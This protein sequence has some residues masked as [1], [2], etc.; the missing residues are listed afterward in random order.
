MVTFCYEATGSKNSES[1]NVD[2][3]GVYVYLDVY[4]RMRKTELP[5]IQTGDRFHDKE[6]MKMC[7][8][9]NHVEAFPAVLVLIC[10]CVG[11]VGFHL[12]RWNP[13][14]VRSR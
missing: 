3:A 8:D 14:L 1:G 10:I 7:D 11:L 6:T 12:N 13:E 4:S 5:T 9:Q 2:T